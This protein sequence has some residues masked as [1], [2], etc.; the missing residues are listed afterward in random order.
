MSGEWQ[1]MS[2]GPLY[3]PPRPG[4][5]RDAPLPGDLPVRVQTVVNWPLIGGIVAGA[6]ALAA[7]I[8][9]VISLWRWA[10]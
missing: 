10:L 3:E 1:T 6:S 7:W 5:N 4:Y 8:P 2:E 9:V